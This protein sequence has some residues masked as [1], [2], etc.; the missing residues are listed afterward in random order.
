MSDDKH[1]NFLNVPREVQ[2]TQTGPKRIANFR[3][4]YKPLKEIEA[5][6]QASRCIDCGNPY[7][8]WKCPVHNHIPAWIKLL[9]K[10]RLFEAAELSHQTNSLPEVCGRICPQDRLCEGACT[11]NND[12]G[13]VTIGSIEKYITDTAFELGWMPDVSGIKKV[14]KRV[15]VIGSG[16]AG[17]GCA[18]ILVRNGVAVDVYDKSPEIGGLLTFGIPNF[19]LEKEVIEKRRKV[20]KHMG[21]KFKL[22]TEVGKDILLPELLEKYDAIFLGMGTYTAITGDLPGLD[23]KNV[24]T[25]L[26]YLVSVNRFQLHYQDSAIDTKNERVVVLGAGDTAMDCNRTALRQGAEKVTCIHRGAMNSLRGSNRDFMN[27][28]DEGTHF[29]WRLQA[30]ELVGKHG[31]VTG[32]R[33]GE[34]KNSEIIQGSEKVIPV[35]RVIVSFGFAPSPAP[36]FVENNIGITKNG[37]IQAQSSRRLR[38]QTANEQIFAGGDMVRGSDLV[39]TAVFDGRNAAESILKYLEVGD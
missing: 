30:L 34:L 33:V 31:K 5:S 9:Q 4:V 13:A 24:H 6:Q 39:V 3:E 36:W 38:G 32:V 18:D 23:L 37:L 35:D 26:D 27:A 20:F 12:F 15:A 1:F 7:C 17:L 8:E 22:N 28:Q 19:K 25:G 29:M 21:I 10:G 14:N 2:K 11:M 16:P